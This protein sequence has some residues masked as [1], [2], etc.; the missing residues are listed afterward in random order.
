MIIKQ[1]N[2]TSLV[3]FKRPRPG[4]KKALRIVLFIINQFNY[5]LDSPPRF[6]SPPWRLLAICEFPLAADCS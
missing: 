3:F 2:H 4:I 6:L 5:L 1:I